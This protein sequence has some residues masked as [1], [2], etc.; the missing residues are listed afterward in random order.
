M[1][2]ILG[3]LIVS[4]SVKLLLFPS[5]HSTDFEVHRNWLA[6]THSLPIQDWYFDTTSIWTLDYPPFFAYFEW[7]LSQLAYYADPKILIISSAPY[8]SPGTIAFQRGSVIVTELVLVLATWYYLH[9]SEPFKASRGKAKGQKDFVFSILCLVMF[10]GGLMLVDHI[11]F[12]YNGMLIGLLVL[13]LAFAKNDKPILLAATFSV[14]VLMK[15]LFLTLA[16]VFALYLILTFCRKQ[17]IPR[18]MLLCSIASASLLV[19]FGPFISAASGSAGM[20]AGQLTQIMSR[21]F[22]FGRGLVHAYWAPNFWALYCLADCLM[23]KASGVTSASTRGLIGDFAPSILPSVPPIASMLLVLL[24]ILPACCAI[25]VKPQPSTL[26]RAAVYTSLSA[27]MFGYHVHEKAILVPMITQTLLLVQADGAGREA[28]LFIL[29]TAV[30]V[31]S[32]FPLF[33]TLPELFTKTAIYVAYMTMTHI[34]LAE[35]LSEWRKWIV[36]L[37]FTALLILFVLTEVAHPLLIPQTLPFLPLMATSALCATML[38][39]CWLLAFQQLWEN[40]A[41]SLEVV[42]DTAQAPAQLGNGSSKRRSLRSLAHA[43]TLIS[44]FQLASGA[45]LIRK[46]ANSLSKRALKK[47]LALLTNKYAGNGLLES[48]LLEYARNGHC[49]LKELIMPNE[50]EK[51]A[52]LMKKEY[53]LRKADAASH[54]ESINGDQGKPPFMQLFNTWRGNQNAAK[55]LLNEQLG[56]IAGQ[57]L[58]VSAVRLYQDSL[59]VKEPG[60]GPTEWHSD[61][62]MCPFNTNDFL[63]MWIPLVP[64]PD[65]D[66]GGTGLSFATKSHVDFSLPFWFNPD[67]V[68]LSDRYFV[69]D[70]GAYALGDVSVHHGWTLHSAPPNLTKETRFALSLSFVADGVPMLPLSEQDN[71]L[72]RVP[73]LEDSQSYRDWI[74]ETGA[75]L[76]HDLC[77]IVYGEAYQEDEDDEE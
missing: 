71:G 52:S 66:N 57:L 11:H 67:E 21:L 24:S 13:C 77:P 2:R 42:G 64:V 55:F 63:T 46:S 49:M 50:V 28:F 58:D 9:G 4:I 59:F 38:I 68:E 44:C 53:K 20:H 36:M 30:G 5:Y 41:V 70:H 12:Q 73:D 33:T 22:P 27:F 72:L 3:G 43:V 40:E 31:Y 8:I 32:L 17:F 74:N 65:Q 23:A 45:E 60:C 6:I 7:L 18:L 15:H 69:N 39:Y 35:K 62:R 34:I 1:I 10:N 54:Y 37:V 19:A 51:M 56:M 26:A 48:T 61:L 29:M 14:L 25:Y 47:P 16:P 76:Q 75:F